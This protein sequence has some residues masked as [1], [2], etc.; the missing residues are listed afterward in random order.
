MR[1]A[2]LAN[3]APPVHSGQ[4]TILDMLIAGYEENV[5]FIISRK[6]GITHY[7]CNNGGRFRYAFLTS[8]HLG[9]FLFL[10]RWIKLFSGTMQTILILRKDKC[11]SFI[12]CSA[13]ILN[14]PV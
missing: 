5:L 10:L 12:A 1:Y 11:Q 7:K 8:L 13:D 6:E 4:P 2:I 14:I 3:V 9:K